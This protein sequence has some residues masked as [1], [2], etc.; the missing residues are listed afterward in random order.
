MGANPIVILGAVIYF[1]IIFYIGWYSK[2]ASMDASDFYVAGR[3]VGPFVNGSALSATFLS[4]AS[5]LGLP[6][7]IFIL[8]YPFWW[9]LAG[10]IAGMPL[11]TLL[12][13][14][15][16][17]K[18]GPTSFTD[19]YADRYGT[20]WMRLIAAFPTI[21]GGFA[22]VIL[23]IVG[24]S[25]FLLCILK[26]N[27]TLSVILATVVVFG[28]VYYGG[29]VAT[30]ISTA[31]QG[32]AM[33]VASLSAGVA[34]LIHYGGL[35]GLTDAVLANSANFFN[36]PYSS[37]APSHPLVG[38]ALG[39]IGFFFVWHFGFSTMP[40][41]VVRFFTSQDIKS[42]RRSVFWSV[43]VGGGMYIGLI[44]IGTSAR[45]LIE[46]LHPL[47]QTEGIN[48]AMGLLTHMKEAYGVAASTVTD[49]SM[50]AAVEAL[51][52]PVLLAVVAA[53]GLAIAMATVAGWTM[54]L[55]VVLGRDLIGKVF[56]SKWPEEQPVQCMRVMTT[57]VLLVSAA[58]SFN[59]PGLLL[60]ISGAAFVVLI[61]SVGPPLVLG[62][63][64][65]RGTTIA[66][67][68]NIIVMTIAAT[69]SWIYAKHALGSNHWFF[70]SDPANK[71]STPHQFYWIFIGYAFYI[72]V[73]LMTPKNDDVVIQK[74]C[75][76]LRP[77][78][79]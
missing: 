54:V 74:Y 41:T 28:Y 22:Y 31:F 2:K 33:T 50:I 72:I 53:G 18:Y 51:K 1:A 45:V 10:I 57:I 34:I 9:A 24:T 75:I 4:P 39:M 48:N 66:A 44:I 32:V 71:I 25:L 59:P 26:L 62:I 43:V 20:K 6:A 3:K 38:T 79:E 15:P 42:A 37:A 65:E 12:T 17:R 46:Q 23:S 76:D 73:S 55:N 56:G 52:S 77:E 16:L 61:A 7:F 58:F 60:D 63:W 13:A 30:T 67:G 5:F 36:S 64:W 40:Y 47:M 11:T 68:L 70:L 14:A 21:I 35:N 69:S 29:M 19:Y 27:F 78:K 8:G 49:Y